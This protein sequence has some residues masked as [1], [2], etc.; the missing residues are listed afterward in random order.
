MDADGGYL[1]LLPPWVAVLKRWPN[2]M[3]MV[4]TGVDAVGDGSP[5]FLAKEATCTL[6]VASLVVPIPYFDRFKPRSPDAAH[7]AH[8]TSFKYARFSGVK[9]V[10]GTSNAW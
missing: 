2:V 8:A 4:L 1:N 3:P 10:F 6:L 7:P 5:P 9:G